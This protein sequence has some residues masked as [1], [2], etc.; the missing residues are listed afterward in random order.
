MGLTLW[1]N[2]DIVD[3]VSGEDDSC[4]VML[5]RAERLLAVIAC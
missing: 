2:C 3:N 5:I 1:N 4:I